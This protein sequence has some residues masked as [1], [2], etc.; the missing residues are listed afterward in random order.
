MECIIRKPDGSTVQMTDK[1]LLLQLESGRVGRDWPA[2][3]DGT[4]AWTSAAEILG[5]TLTE[6]EKESAA[7]LA[8]MRSAAS[9]RSPRR[10]SNITRAFYVS[11]F[12]FIG[13]VMFRIIAV[14]DS[15]ALAWRRPAP[16]SGGGVSG[17]YA[18]L[19][20]LNRQANV[21]AVRDMSLG[22]V[23]V[24]GTVCL[25]LFVLSRRRTSEQASP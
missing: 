8:A 25:L 10:T 1:V 9:P 19:E 11:L 14:N 3:V 17:Y 4:E 12:A 23:T 15:S 16:S 18:R 22:A 7:S 21:E 6:E 20:S 5:Q 13:A 24:T 2:R